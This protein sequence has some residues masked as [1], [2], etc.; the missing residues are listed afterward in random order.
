MFH[1]MLT[2][3]S[4]F[5][6]VWMFNAHPAEACSTF[7][8]HTERGVIFGRNTD[9]GLPVPGFFVVNKRGIQKTALPWGMLLPSVEAHPTPTW[10]SRY[11]SVTVTAFGREFPDGG[12]NEAGLVVEEMTL[13]ETVYPQASSDRSVVHMQWIQYQLDNHATVDELLANLDKI[14]PRGWGWHFMVAD[15]SGACATIEFIEGKAVVSRG[16]H[17]RGCVLTN[18]TLDTSLKDLNQHTGFGGELA[19]PQD[20]NSAAR[21]VRASLRLKQAAT[22]APQDMIEFGFGVLE[23]VSQGPDTIR[24]IVHNLSSRTIYF[25]THAQ[26]SVKYIELSRLNFSPN[27]PLLMIS[28]DSP[29]EGDVTGQLRPYSPE[30]NR[31]VVSDFVSLLRAS[32]YGDSLVRDE[33]EA[34]NMTID[35]YIE[36]IATYPATTRVASGAN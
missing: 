19:E 14:S 22:Q 4:A 3:A 20:R 24:S 30:S 11:G 2:L 25:R 34:G 31:S 33:L 28:T 21:F 13:N 10:V 15:P 29:L 26:P 27:S 23:D 36:R 32:E 5:A 6:V 12:M 7:V 18:G 9:S 35:A 1:R 17:V 16:G 8:L